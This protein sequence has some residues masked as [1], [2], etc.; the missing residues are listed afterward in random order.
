M[1]N[2]ELRQSVAII[3]FDRPEKYNSFTRDM[4][5][6]VQENLRT[7]AD[8]E[9]I[10]AVLLTGSGKAFGA[11]Q[12]LQEVV[13]DNGVDISKILQEHLNPIVRQLR[14]LAKPVVAA[15]NG[16]A[17][18]AHANIA[19]ACD[20]IVA[21]ESASFIQAFTKIGLIPDSGGTYLLPRAIGRARASA[22]MLLG[23]KV[24]ATEAER[25]GMIYKVLPDE[26]F[27]SSALAIAEKLA[28]MP[29]RALALTKEAI[30]AAETNDLDA[31]LELED[32]LQTTAAATDDY[33]EGVNAFLEKRRPVFRGR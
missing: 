19:L 3:R 16:V 10:R 29:T 8:D 31:Q 4:A 28:K 23:D 11:G 17:A 12:D 9:N 2:F 13:E 20:V 14:S 7:C 27:E 1:K 26:D 5:L 30:I 21:A 15:V 24:S 6:R 32:R 25:M 22:L 18:G 33:A